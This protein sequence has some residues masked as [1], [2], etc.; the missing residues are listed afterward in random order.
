[1][2]SKI[3]QLTEDPPIANQMWAC[4]SFISPELQELRSGKNGCN[5]E[6]Q[7]ASVLRIHNLV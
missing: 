1:M 5:L 2:T 4:V 7:L 3:D 6:M